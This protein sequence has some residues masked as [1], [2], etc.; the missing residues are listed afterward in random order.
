MTSWRKVQLFE[1]GWTLMHKSSMSVLLTSDGQQFLG[2]MCKFEPIN[3]LHPVKGKQVQQ[4][5]AVEQREQE[6]QEVES[7]ITF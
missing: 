6:A 7:Y 2:M 5:G 3:F 4:S 1:V